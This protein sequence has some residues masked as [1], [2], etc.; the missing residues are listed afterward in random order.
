MA[1]Y[2]TLINFTDRGVLQVKDTA[3]GQYNVVSD[4]R[5][6]GRGLHDRA[7]RG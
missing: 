4:R 1:T 3:K 2:V 5:R 6:A 7:A